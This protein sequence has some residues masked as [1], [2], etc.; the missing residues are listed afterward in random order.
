MP[1]IG[2]LSD[3]DLKRWDEDK[4]YQEKMESCE[5]L[6][7]E[8]GEHCKRMTARPENWSPW[9]MGHDE[10]ELEAVPVFGD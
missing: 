4:E 10:P 9:E 8:Y 2:P 6:P 3:S 1:T 5:K 7:R